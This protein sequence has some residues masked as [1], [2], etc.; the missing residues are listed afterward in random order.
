MNLRSATALSRCDE[1]FDYTCSAR[2]RLWWM[3]AEARAPRAR[4]TNLLL[5]VRAWAVLI[6]WHLATPPTA[7]RLAC[8]HT[9]PWA[10]PHPGAHVARAAAA[11]AAFGTVPAATDYDALIERTFAP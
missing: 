4:M 9:G 8:L 7:I 11:P 5:S 10:Q 6:R 3:P 1:L 2:T